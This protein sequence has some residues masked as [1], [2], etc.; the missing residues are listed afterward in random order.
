MSGSAV[1][2]IWLFAAEEARDPTWLRTLATILPFLGPVLVGLIAAPWIG[3][4]IRGR[5][6]GE[7]P[8]HEAP[9]Q[10]TPTP[11]GAGLPPPVAQEAVQRA[12]ADPLLRLLIE[13]L[14]HRLSAAHGEIAQL[15]IEKSADSGNMARLA[16]EIEDQ[17]TRYRACLAELDDKTGQLRAVRG[18][19]EEI[20]RELEVTQRKLRICMD[21]WEGRM[22]D[23]ASQ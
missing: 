4:K 8:R 3:E 19:L 10:D 6:N 15:H 14:H 5:R 11:P 13:D 18:R 17:E 16:A 12:E 2:L 23:D 21:Q 22:R 1:T 7:A 20:K 9:P